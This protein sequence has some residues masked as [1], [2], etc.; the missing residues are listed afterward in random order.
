MDTLYLKVHKFTYKIQIAY[1]WIVASCND[2]VDAALSTFRVKWRW[3][4]HSPSKRWYLYRREQLKS[5]FTYKIFR[6]GTR[7][8]L[9]IFI[10]EHGTITSLI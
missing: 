3:R 2:T 9:I 1:F 6:V 10:S 4:Q 8:I 7:P 5:F